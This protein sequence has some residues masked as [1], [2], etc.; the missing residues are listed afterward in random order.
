[1]SFPRD[2][3]QAQRVW[4]RTYVEL[5]EQPLETA[6]LR[7]RL[8]LLTRVIDAHPFWESSVGRSPAARVE[9]RRQARERAGS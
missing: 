9:L 5:A 4:H 1:M 2:L 8:Q 7:R 6:A 3:V